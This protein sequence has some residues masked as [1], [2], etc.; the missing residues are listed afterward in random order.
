MESYKKLIILNLIIRLPLLFIIQISLFSDGLR[1]FVPNSLGIVRG[2][3]FF[4]EPPLF[5]ILEGFWS[6]FFSEL[7]LEFF[8]KLTPFLFFIGIL[9]LLPSLYGVL[10][11]KDKE[12]LIVTALLLFSSWSLLV[13]ASVMMEMLS[14]AFTLLLFVFLEKRKSLSLRDCFLIAFLTI[15]IVYTK[16]TGYFILMGFVLYAFFRFKSLKEKSLVVLSIVLGFL[17][18]VPWLIKNKI[19]GVPELNPIREMIFSRTIKFFSE[20]FLG[21][22]WNSIVECYHYFW[23][24]P[25]PRQA[26]FSGVYNVLYNTYYLGFL[27]CSLVLSL[28]IIL[29]LVKFGRK[30]IRY[31]ILI[32]PLFA[33]TFLWSFLSGFYENSGRYLFVF[34][35]FFYFFAVKFI[36]SL[37][38]KNLKR[39]IYLILTCLILLFVITAYATS[40]E[41]K[42][43]HHQIRQIASEV[44]ENEFQIVSN[45]GFV[46]SSIWYY[47]D[48]EAYSEEGESF[49][50]WGLSSD[51]LVLDLRT[52]DLY[53]NNEIYYVIKN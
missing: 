17:F 34:H 44:Q 39:G 28:L 41:M 23:F 7:V 9:F 10:K 31:L 13:G 27:F 37:K 3:L 4:T 30:N 53:L 46:V 2:N 8:W 36:S 43:R 48:K 1:R 26:S 14:M 50:S 5:F 33:F 52:Y 22:L 32:L 47:A 11:L 29:G 42:S 12:K 25:L 19:L 24:I 51:N 35:L 6:L 45:E 21:N 38:S 20:N 40:F 15:L 16:Q 18:Y 49:E